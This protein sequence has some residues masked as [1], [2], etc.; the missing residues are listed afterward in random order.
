ETPLSFRHLLP[1]SRA[2]LPHN[3]DYAIALEGEWSGGLL[4]RDPGTLEMA[5]EFTGLEH[6]AH[7][8]AAAH[9]LAL[10]VELGDGRP[11]GKDLDAVAQLGVREHIGAAVFDAEII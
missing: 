4:D 11:V 6:L 8:V 5:L 7:D 10:D 2:M 9:E 1:E 3:P